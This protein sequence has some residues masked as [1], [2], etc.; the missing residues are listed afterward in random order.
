M[1]ILPAGS[2]HPIHDVS[3]VVAGEMCIPKP[4]SNAAD[5]NIPMVILASST[6]S[7]QSKTTTIDNK[8]SLPT[9]SITTEKEMLDRLEQA[10]D[11]W[12][13][14][15][16]EQAFPILK[17]LANEHPQAVFM[18]GEYWE[19]KQ[20]EKLAYEYYLQAAKQGHT[21]A[22]N[23]VGICFKV[24]YGVEQ[25]S[26]SARHWF[27]MAALQNNANA[28]YTLA[29]YFAEDKNEGKYA[30][31][32]QKAA[33][34]GQTDAQVEIADNYEQG[35]YGF[36]QNHKTA[37]AWYEQAAF[38]NNAKAHFM[39]GWYYC[40][41]KGAVAIDKGLAMTHF[42]KAAALGFQKAYCPLGL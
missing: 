7:P 34:G 27:H 39:L 42:L 30:K 38:Q 1:V 28:Q 31:W 14:D 16:H 15:E 17:E 26:K 12:D 22:Q 4:V 20:D 11:L 8:S 10:V 2:L 6:D 41:G 36:E 25:D 3:T 23:A 18:L 9:P 5:P 37:F 13:M 21:D 19:Q 24:G 35:Q 33:N 29:K 40:Y 32:L